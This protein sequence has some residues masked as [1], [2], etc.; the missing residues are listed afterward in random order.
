MTAIEI[1]ALARV[2]RIEATDTRQYGTRRDSRIPTS[3][4]R[5]E[6][7]ARLESDQ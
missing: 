1:N 7:V 2:G 6:G 3:V 4:V 5:F